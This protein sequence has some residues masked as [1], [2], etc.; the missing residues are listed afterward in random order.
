L[1]Q[2]RSEGRVPKLDLSLS[3]EERD[4][5]LAEQRTARLATCGRAGPQVV[6]LW[7]V[8]LGGSM[9]LNTTRG[10]LTI[11]NL[12][13]DPRAA[14]TVDDGFDY[15]TLRGVVLRGTVVE[16]GDDDRLQEVRSRWSRKY[17]EGGP[18]PFERWRNRVWL[19]LDPVHESSWDFRKM[20]EAR[21]RRAAE[22]RTA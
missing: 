10:N 2:T 18:V 22:G 12:A 11:V 5:F 16:A 8:W 17:L 14:A 15:E 4:A 3:P 21:A 13:D 20:D 6:P 19:R 9:Y 7:F 1:S